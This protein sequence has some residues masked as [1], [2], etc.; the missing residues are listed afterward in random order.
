MQGK[1]DVPRRKNLSGKE[2]EDLSGGEEGK[3]LRSV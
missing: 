2:G 1:G 3:I